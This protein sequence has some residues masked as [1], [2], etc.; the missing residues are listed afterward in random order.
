M[1]LELT[2]NA[3]Q[4]IPASSQGTL[5]TPRPNLIWCYDGMT[6]TTGGRLSFR[7]CVSSPIKSIAERRK[8]KRK[9]QRI[10]E[11]SVQTGFQDHTPN[12]A[13]FLTYSAL[14]EN[15]LT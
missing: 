10:V 14:V 1:L 13:L 4:M 11:T 12:Q 6:G 15:P 2:P 8:K 3:F 9:R 7:S 5:S